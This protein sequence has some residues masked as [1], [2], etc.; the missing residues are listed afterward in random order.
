MTLMELSVYLFIVI[1]KR[2]F[3][4]Y[5][6]EKFLNVFSEEHIDFFL[7]SLELFDETVSQ[8]D[9][10][11]KKQILSNF[12]NQDT[13]MKNWSAYEFGNF[14]YEVFPI[15]GFQSGIWL[16]KTIVRGRK[17]REEGEYALGKA[18]W[19]PQRDKRN[20]DIYK[21]MRIVKKGD[22]VLHLVDNQTIVG[23]SKVI[24]EYNSDFSCLPGTNWDNGTGKNPGYLIRLS[25]FTRFENP[26]DRDDIFNETNKEKLISISQSE[27]GVFYNRNLN[28]R[29]GAYLTSVPNSLLSIINN[30]FREKNGIDLP[31]IDSYFSTESIDKT[32]QDNHILES[33]SPDFV[34]EF[35][36]LLRDKKQVILFGP[37]GT[38]KTYFA[39]NFAKYFTKS[40]TGWDLIQFHPSYS[41]EDFVEGITTEIVDGQV[42]YNVTP[43]I[44]RQICEKASKDKNNSFVLII[45]EINRGNLAKIFGELIFSLEYRDES[46]NLPY[47]SKKFRIPDNLFIIGT[48]N[49]AD[50][51][52][53]LVD[54]ALRRR[55][56]FIE[57]WPDEDI[58]MY[59]LEKAKV[60]LK[61]KI[62]SIFSTFNE[63]IRN[64]EKLGKHFQL[65]QTYFFV[66]SR[67]ELLR[68]WKYAVKPLLEE[69]LF[70][71]ENE[72]RVFEDELNNILSK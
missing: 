16:E 18:L 37:P 11:R 54:Y 60:D 59:W 39:I 70:G 29:Q 72:L 10:M 62:I 56:Y 45:D 33:F 2:K 7:K 1:S 63:S 48:M 40:G 6:P 15:S 49:T 36:E 26:I 52:I 67:D 13:T 65:G 35:E 61:E 46:V 8:L 30:V 21:N 25:E 66:K 43:K 38:S 41:Y 12:K 3:S 4:L 68:N 20:A 32:G 64:N 44:L 58:L 42:K 28:L 14:L 51:S 57:M 27:R 50:R 34:K 31:Y 19:S 71:E 47:S 23:I 69:Y 17:D 22:L 5:F 9:P 53:A 24:E 55:F